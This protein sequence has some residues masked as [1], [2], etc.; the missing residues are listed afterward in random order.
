MAEIESPAL[1]ARRVLRAADRATLATALADPTGDWPYASLVLVAFAS[2]A[3]PLL[4]ISD[5]AEHTK[6]LKRNQRASLMVDATA[7]LADPLTGARLTVVGEVARSGDER[8][9]ERYAARHPAAAVYRDFHDFALYRMIPR[10]AHLVAGFGRI[11]WIDAAA[12]QPPPEAVA[13]L[14]AAEPSILAHMNDDHAGTVD[15][16]AQRLLGR[17]GTGWRL[18]GVD[19]DGADLR[20]DAAVA[21][22]DF[23]APV[24]DGDA[25][26]QEFIRLAALARRN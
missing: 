7:G 25:V 19:P 16:Y 2:D 15:L 9:L 8:L 18:T 4:L 22:L 5:L 12:L 26:R 11:H 10:R 17:T 3:S 20:L 13:F 14:E 1:T 6:N 21:R 23:A 24:A